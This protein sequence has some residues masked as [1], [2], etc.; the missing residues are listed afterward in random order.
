MN[1]NVPFFYKQAMDQS[2]KRV[3]FA[4]KKI[5]P[6]YLNKELFNIHL[7]GQAAGAEHIL[8]TILHHKKDPDFDITDLEAAIHTFISEVLN[9]LTQENYHV[10]GFPLERVLNT[11]GYL[12]KDINNETKE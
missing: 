4:P 11:H 2:S 8:A 9:V 10:K 12:N 5:T 6:I 3:R 1:K 7:L